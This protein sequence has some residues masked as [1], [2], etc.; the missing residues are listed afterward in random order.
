[1]LTCGP[2]FLRGGGGSLEAHTVGVGAA[3]TG[4]QGR[5][6]PGASTTSRYFLPGSPDSCSG[7]PC[8][9]SL[10]SRALPRP[11]SAHKSPLIG[12][13]GVSSQSFPAYSTPSFGSCS[14]QCPVSGPSF[15]GLST[16]RSCANLPPLWGLLV[17]T[18]LHASQH[19]DFS[20]QLGQSF[21]AISVQ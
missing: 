5:W 14:K 10:A 13:G 8:N 21:Q 9:L 11:A 19:Y 15:P 20:P 4:E 17:I 1:M 18:G 6:R 7:L 2:G 12:H 3:P 16:S